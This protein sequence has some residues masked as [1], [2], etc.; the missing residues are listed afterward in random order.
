[1]VS[2]GF[3]MGSNS[4]PAGDITGA[5]TAMGIFNRQGVARFFLNFQNFAKKSNNDPPS[6]F[7]VF[8]PLGNP[9][10]PGQAGR[11]GRQDR[12]DRQAGRQ[13][14]SKKKLEHFLSVS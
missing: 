4:F 8:W 11:Q 1:M 14:K 10:D 3:P 13:E 2:I 9:E 7:W 6:T 5:S 12:Q